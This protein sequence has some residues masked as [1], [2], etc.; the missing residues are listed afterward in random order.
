MSLSTLV[1]RIL[2]WILRACGPGASF[3]SHTQCYQVRQTFRLDQDEH[4]VKLC[5][6]AVSQSN[7]C[8][9]DP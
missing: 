2:L 7:D 3:P 1:G 6:L 4:L 8:Y 9:E 5:P